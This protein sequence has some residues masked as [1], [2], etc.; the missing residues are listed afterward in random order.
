MRIHRRAVALLAVLALTLAALPA[1]ADE[2][3]VPVQVVTLDN[4]MKLLMVERHESPI[5]SAGWVAHVGSVNERPGITGI[6][7]LFEVFERTGSAR[8]VVKHFREQGLRFPRRPRQGPH[9]G[10]L[11]WEPLRHWRVLRVLHTLSSHM[12]PDDQV[13]WFSR[14][15]PPLLRLVLPVTLLI[16]HGNYIFWRSR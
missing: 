11:L 15:L 8:A 5:V 7:H 9:K 16:S 14:S 10:E 3:K 6:A 1:T 12:I 13:L 2:A 4:G